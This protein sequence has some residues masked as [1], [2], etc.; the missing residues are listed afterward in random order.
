[1]YANIYIYFLIL[2]CMKIQYEIFFLYF[3][4]LSHMHENKAFCIFNIYIYIYI[5]N[6][7]EKTVYVNTKFVFL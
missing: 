7:A 3:E 2:F 6:I 5:H 4:R 1:M